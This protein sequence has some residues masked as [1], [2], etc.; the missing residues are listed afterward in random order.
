MQ[1]AVSITRYEAALEITKSIGTS[2]G[3]SDF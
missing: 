3:V 1:N 2:A